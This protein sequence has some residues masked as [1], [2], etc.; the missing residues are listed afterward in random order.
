MSVATF[1]G[2]S[3]IGSSAAYAKHAAITTGVGTT[4]FATELV[5]STVEGYHSKDAQLAARRKAALAAF[6][7]KSAK[8]AVA[9]EPA[10]P[11]EPAATESVIVEPAKAAKPTASESVIVDGVE[12]IVE[13]AKSAWPRKVVVTN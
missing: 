11:A 2:R 12:V 6:A 7:A 9:A 1:I 13:P 10:K 3:V 4:R 8:P 5:S